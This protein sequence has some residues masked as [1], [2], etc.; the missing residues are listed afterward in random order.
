VEES[1]GGEN[2]V[3]EELAMNRSKSEW[4][5]LLCS[6]WCS[7]LGNDEQRFN[8]NWPTKWWLK[9]WMAKKWKVKYLVEKNGGI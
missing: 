2:D 6:S 1:D 9:E 3:E 5:R 4:R 7:V 8:G